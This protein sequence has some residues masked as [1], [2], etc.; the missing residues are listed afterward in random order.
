MISFYITKIIEKYSVINTCQYFF[1]HIK[2]PLVVKISVYQPQKSE[3]NL[4][5][6]AQYRPQECKALTLIL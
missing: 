4:Q 1:V 3:G 2:G 6:L 5:N